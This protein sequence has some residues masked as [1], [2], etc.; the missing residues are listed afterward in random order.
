[1]RFDSSVRWCVRVYMYF[2]CIC[3]DE[4]VNEYELWNRTEMAWNF[5]KHKNEITLQ[6]YGEWENVWVFLSSM[7]VL[8]LL[9]NYVEKCFWN[10]CMH[11]YPLMGNQNVAYRHEFVQLDE[12][13]EMILSKWRI[14]IKRI[15]IEF[16]WNLCSTF[17]HFD[18]VLSTE[19]MMM[20]HCEQ[21]INLLFA[22]FHS[23][24]WF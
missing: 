16:H 12:M 2:M 18:A 8:I 6:C 24:L 14:D 4:W 17:M 11:H 9:W 15:E 19:N 22:K 21:H 5:A 13:F 7:M 3:V 20:M 23:M 10:P 1:M